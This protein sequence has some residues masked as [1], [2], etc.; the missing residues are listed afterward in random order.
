MKDDELINEMLK[1]V[2]KDTVRAGSPI[3]TEDYF[4]FQQVTEF[5]AEKTKWTGTVMDLLSEMKCKNICPTTAAKLLHKYGKTV[6]KRDCV[7][8][9]FMRTNRRR[10]VELRHKGD[11]KSDRK[12]DSIVHDISDMF[13]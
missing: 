7:T 8:V 13:R 12:R 2:A 5:M 1:P 9:K 4:F 10:L 6:L 3:L 11:G